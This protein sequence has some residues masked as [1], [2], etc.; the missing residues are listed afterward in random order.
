M[1]SV[2]LISARAGKVFNRALQGQQFIKLSRRSGI[3][4]AASLL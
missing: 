2:L 4:V 1:T 3:G